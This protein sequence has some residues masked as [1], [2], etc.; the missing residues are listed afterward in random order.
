VERRS[1]NFDE[2][3]QKLMEARLAAALTADGYKVPPMPAADRLRDLKARQL[4]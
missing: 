2:E 3:I 4:R 1:A